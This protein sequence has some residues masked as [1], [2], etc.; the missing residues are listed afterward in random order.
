MANSNSF[1]ANVVKNLASFS[2]PKK[3]GSALMWINVFSTALA[4]A[5]NTFAAAQDKNTSSE[6]KKFL[7]PAG[8]ATGV[9]NVGL[10]LALTLNVIKTME[11]KAEDVIKTMVN[12]NTIEKNTLEY[13]NKAVSKAQSGLFNTGLFAKKPK[14]VQDMKNYLLE[15]GS[16][17]NILQ[18]GK[19]TQNAIQEYKDTIKGCASVTGAFIGVIV[20]YGIL[21]PII[22]DVSAYFVQKHMEKKNPNWKDAPYKPYFDPSHFK[23]GYASTKQPLNMNTYM[24]FTR[25]RNV[26]PN[27]S[28]KV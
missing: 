24:A 25:S 7:V 13:V 2:D 6:D 11:K 10:Y 17:K 23:I 26:V 19:V 20:G 5:T 28:L 21:S 14:Y 22:R 9:A 18:D 12:N 15:D 1:L 3:A 27:A 4:A 16:V 8:I